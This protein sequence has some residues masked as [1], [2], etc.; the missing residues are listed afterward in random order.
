MV[1]WIMVRGGRRHQRAGPPDVLSLN[2]T[3]LIKLLYL[4][5]LSPRLNYCML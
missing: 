2:T 4:Q 3:I 1:T 5:D